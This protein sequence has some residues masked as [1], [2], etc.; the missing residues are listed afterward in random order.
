MKLS[1]LAGRIDAELIGDGAIEVTSVGPLD[2]AKPGQVSFLAN[3]KYMK[4]LETTLAAAVIVG[5]NMRVDRVP[6]LVT[7]DPYYAFSRTIVALHGYRKHPFAG[8]HPHATIEPTASV[9]KG[10]IIYPGVYVGARAKIG[11]DSILY[12]NVVVYDDCVIG[13]RCIIHAGAIIGA[14]GYGFALN[15]GEHH[16]IPQIGNVVIED[17]VEIGPNTTISRAA[18]ESTTICKGTK[19]DQQVVVGHNVK[20]GPH[21]LLVAQVAIAGSSTVGH[22]TTL[23]GQVGVAGHLTIGDKIVVGA[24]A[25]V[26]HD[27]EEPGIYIGTP[28]MP[29]AHARRVYS[30]FTELPELQ[31]RVKELEQRLADIAAEE[32]PEIV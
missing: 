2:C 5:K 19:I 23:A 4:Q 28:A 12:P 14:D 8:I 20:V 15:D 30:I 29:F 32:G 1:E 16:K 17:D 26:M 27:L 24:Q 25:G 21:C 22:H 31:K 13:D 11:N 9:G 10:T 18:L 3:A 7:R 6:L